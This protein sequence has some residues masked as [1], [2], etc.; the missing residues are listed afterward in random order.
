MKKYFENAMWWILNWWHTAILAL[1]TLVVIGK[2]IFD[3]F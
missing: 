1:A 2:L 3:I